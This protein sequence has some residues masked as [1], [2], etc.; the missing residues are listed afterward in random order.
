M[1]PKVADAKKNNSVAQCI[2]MLIFCTHLKS[3]VGGSKIWNF[4]WSHDLH[5]SL[6]PP[7]AFS[8]QNNV[9]SFFK[10]VT[11]CN[12]YYDFTAVFMTYSN[13]MMLL[14]M[15][16]EKKCLVVTSL[17]PFLWLRKVVTHINSVPW[18]IIIACNSYVEIY[19]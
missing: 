18:S 3:L 2:I 12:C 1:A 17:V 13:A 6:S 9:T 15:L 19:R 5:V 14:F 16:A 4:I 10:C 11:I 8:A 7:G